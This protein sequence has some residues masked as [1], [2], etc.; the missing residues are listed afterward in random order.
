MSNNTSL[1]GTAT[2]TGQVESKNFTTLYSGAANAIPVSVVGN[3]TYEIASGGVAGGAN[4]N[5]IGSDA[6][7]DSVK[8]ASGLNIT[9]SST[10]ANT[11][12]LEG[13]SY[14]IAASATTGGANFNLTDSNAVTDTIKFAGSGGTT[15]TYTDAN[16]ITISSTG[17]GGAT[18]LGN[19]SDVTLTS[20][21]VGNF[22]YYNG[23]KWVNSDTIATTI[24]ANRPVFQYDNS[25]AGVNN[26][27]FIRK[28]YGATPYTTN[29]GTG[30]AFQLDSDS[31]V[32]NQYASINA[33]WD[34]TAPA[35]NLLTNIN[36]NA[37]GPFINVGSFST[38]LAT[39]KGDLTVQGGTLTLNGSTSGT[40][41]LNAPAI[42]GTQDYTLPTAYPA[43]NGYALV[44]TTAGV[45]SWAAIPGGGG[46]GTFGNITVAVVDSNTI[47]TTTGN[48]K[49]DSN[50]G[51]I[52]MNVP[53]ITTD[54][55]TLALFNTTATT[56]N[57]FGASTTTNI[58][59]SAGT[60]NIPGGLNVDSGTLFVDRTNN[61]VGINNASPAYE[62][63][64]GSSAD[65]LSQFAMTNSER[66][67]IFT[68]N[69]GDDLF[70]F[71]YN[72]AN[73]LQFDLSNQWFNSGR[74]G[75][76]T[77]TPGYTLHVNGDAYVNSNLTVHGST[78]LGNN[79]ITDS[80]TVT[81]NFNVINN[82]ISNLY[83]DYATGNVGIFNTIP[84]Y[85]LDVN[86]I[87]NTNSSVVCAD[88]IVDGISSYN[89]QTTTTT[90]TTPVSISGT[91]RVSQ[92]V[93]IKIIDNVT[94]ELH[95]LEALAFRKGTTAYLTTY[96]E[97]YTNTALA[98]FTA[99][100][101]SGNTRIL[102]TPATTNNTTFT[103]VRITLD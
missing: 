77:A 64:I 52:A 75:V 97:M 81:G 98:T 36:N 85:P 17:S 54:A 100:V 6:S 79:Y 5:L 101:L 45:M 7:I 43:S 37:T 24:A 95:V 60:V 99:D 88:V 2:T 86:G 65:A 34:A 21:T 30:V 57:A 29:D 56:V 23:T 58:G 63:Q 49:L 10:D 96:A 87:I 32:T 20:P 83:V 66:T 51:T 73:R 91:T 50:S 28:N 38:A 103:A 25:T 9:V 59:N 19:L 90:S 69:T 13:V 18:S 35:I 76:N 102:A 71:N 11:I 12:Q 22:L 72:S 4:L 92:K 74:L 67:A 46:S 15:I 53:T 82:S 42:A 47:S 78:I 33:T 31:Q 89:T 41:A 26:G 62:L 8:F 94:G 68:S 61:R 93:V 39:L 16:T 1:F 48:L 80:T 14:N 70:S 27:I 84:A 44:S 55:T 3:T 40:V